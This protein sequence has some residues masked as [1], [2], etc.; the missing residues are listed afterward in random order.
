MPAGAQYAV[1]TPAERHVILFSD[2]KATMWR[3]LC[4]DD[5]EFAIDNLD[6]EPF[7]GGVWASHRI[8]GALGFERQGTLIFRS[9][10]AGGCKQVRRSRCSLTTDSRIWKE[11]TVDLDADYES[12]V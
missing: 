1:L 11:A 2:P 6:V 12:Y 5:I 10:F 9:D 7:P 8:I 3:P 4:L